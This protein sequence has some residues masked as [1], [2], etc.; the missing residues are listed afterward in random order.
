M[1]K[2][3]LPKIGKARQYFNDEDLIPKGTRA[4]PGCPAELGLRIALRVF[5]RDAIFFG[6]PSCM[7]TVMICLLYTSPS[8]RD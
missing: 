5:G 1:A 6:G 7:T 2:K 4:C 3:R 8:P